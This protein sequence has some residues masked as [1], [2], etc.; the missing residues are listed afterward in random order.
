MRD[1]LSDAVQYSGGK[2][3]YSRRSLTGRWRCKAVGKERRGAG[4]S[5]ALPTMVPSKSTHVVVL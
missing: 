4:G 3:M 1:R 2:C 5:S